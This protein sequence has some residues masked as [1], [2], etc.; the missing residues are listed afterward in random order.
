MVRAQYRETPDRA[1]L[2]AERW[3]PILHGS[4]DAKE[5]IG[6]MMEKRKPMFRGR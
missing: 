2:M 6:A 1:M 4:E 5:G 3:H